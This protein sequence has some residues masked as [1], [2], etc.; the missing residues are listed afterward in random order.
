MVDLSEEYRNAESGAGWWADGRRGRLTLAGADAT[1]FLQALVTADVSAVGE[2]GGAYAAYLTPQGR[3]IA[4]LAL[5]RRPDGWLADVPA[6]L[7]AS[8]AARLD[9]LVFTEDVRIAEATDTFACLSVA[10][11]D[12]THLLAAAIGLDPRRLGALALR[13]T[14]TTAEG[15]V[16]AATDATRLRSFDLFVASEARD[17][18]MGRLERGRIVP[19]HVP[20]AEAFRIHAGRPAFGP[21]LQDDTIPLEAG[22]LER[23]ISTTKG[24]YVGQVVIV[25][26]LHRG[27][28]R[29]ARRL[30]R[31]EAADP[32]RELAVG[33]ALIV[34]DREVG[35]ITSAAWSSG[36]NRSVA[37]GYIRREIAEAGPAIVAQSADGL[38]PVTVTGQAG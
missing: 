12:A 21:D 9:G 3:M 30:M 35:Q 32:G 20:T 6:P 2:T 16:V 28:G 34:E 5:Y 10:G 36:R 18:L 37:L 27:G 11:G 29:V 1:T 8:L 25:R 7:A 15:L 17:A 4:D 22:L 33:A 19:L 38:L 31:L 26:V 14:I 13:S 24:C 23:A